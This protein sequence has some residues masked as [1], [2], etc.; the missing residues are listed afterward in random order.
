MKYCFLVIS[1]TLFFSATGAAQDVN[2]QMS[3]LAWLAGCWNSDDKTQ[4][5]EQ[6]TKLAG[7]AMFGISRTI[8]DG[9]TASFE[10]MQIR[11]KG[12]DIFYIAQPDGGPAV[13]FKL[14][15]LN[16]SAAI[17]A[18]DNHD[19]P[20]RIIYQRQIDGSL[21]AAIEGDVSGKAKRI[22]Y[23]MKRVRCD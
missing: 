18:N 11:E 13:P 1:L 17:F 5:E 20:Q 12:S 10:F 8:K 23:A 2:P 15:K 14:V 3:K 9:Q 21:F 22:E 19:F 7:K 16:D 6:W 4:T